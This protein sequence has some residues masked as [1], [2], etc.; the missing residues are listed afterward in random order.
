MDTCG[1]QVSGLDDVEFY[2]DIDQ[3]DVDA[4][5]RPGK[6]NPFSTKAFDDLE[7]RGS[8][9]HPTLLYE[10]EDKENSSQT[11]SVSGRPT[12]PRALL[13]CRSFRARLEN[14]PDYVSTNL[15]Q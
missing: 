6:G 10:E 14:V 2:W 13:R 1:Y 12:G 4:V 7:L 3:L 5:S 11:T 9:E 15:F 8:A